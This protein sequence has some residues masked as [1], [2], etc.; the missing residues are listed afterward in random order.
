MSSE[1]ALERRLGGFDATTVGVG[2]MVGAG[3][4]VVF[5]P[6]AGA[7]GSWLLLSL[8]AAAVV[9]YCNAMASAQLA[10]KH[11]TSGGTYIYGR[12]QLGEWP[13]FLA[14]WGYITGKTSSCAAMALA[15]GLYAFPDYATAAAVA[16]V[17]LLT[18]INLMGI[19]RTAW[20]T[21]WFVSIVVAILVFLVVV[22][23]DAPPIGETTAAVETSP[24]GVLQA[25]G[26]FFFAFA[27]YARIATMGEEVREPAKL[28]PRAIMGALAF[29][30]VLYVALGLALLDFMGAGLLA[31]TPAPLLAVGEAVGGGV[32]T[33]AVTVA[34]TLGCLG[35]LLALIAGVSRT[36]FAMAREGDLPRGLATVWPRFKVPYL[37]DLTVAVVVIFLLLTQDVLAVVGFSSFGVLI[38]YAVT[39]ASALTLKDRPWYAPKALNILGLAGCLLLAFTLPLASVLTMAGV[40]AVGLLGRAVLKPGGRARNHS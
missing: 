31:A 29:T 22:A 25:A 20:M 14:G 34:A 2:S 39:N 8:V 24:Y 12:R 23:F 28:I 10:A 26:L 35:A 11:P 27:G 5:S 7:A 38:Y 16:A 30:L 40:L 3:V 13:G 36:M 17:M 32:G 19:T 15:F 4:F 21:R 6:A 1:S 33:A 37:A 18:G 9:A